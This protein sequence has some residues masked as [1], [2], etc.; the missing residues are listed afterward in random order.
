VKRAKDLGLITIV[1]PEG[2]GLKLGNGARFLFADGSEFRE[3]TRCVVTFGVD[4][5]ISATFDVAIDP[6]QNIEAHPL[7]SLAAVKAAAAHHGYIVVKPPTF[8]DR[9]AFL[10]RGAR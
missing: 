8:I 9:L 2:V 6:R 4:E 1:P 3:V 5:V 7:L 10:F